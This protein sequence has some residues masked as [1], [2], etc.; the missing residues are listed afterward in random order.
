M[1]KTTFFEYLQNTEDAISSGR[2]HDAMANCQHI[3][4]FFPEALEAQRLL[5][6]VYLAQG[7]LEEAQ[8][9][10]DWILVND[11]ENVVV[12]CD[13]AL[14]SERL[15][16][17]DTALD[18][19][20][21]AYELSRGNSQIRQKFNQLSA[22]VGQQEFMFSRAG[23]ARLYMRGDL[24]TQAEQEW[25]VVLNA[26]PERLD[27]RAGLLETCW[28]EGTYDKVEQLATQILEEIPTC[29][30]ALLLLAHVTST[31]NLERSKELLL[32]AETLDP[33]MVMA[34]ELFSD[35]MVSQPNNPF[36]AMLKK[37]PIVFSNLSDDTQVS[38]NQTAINSM[39]ESN[40]SQRFVETTDQVYHPSN[41]ET[42]SEL[43]TQQ[44]SLIDI[45]PVE[46]ITAFAS[47]KEISN[48]QH[49]D[50]ITT[51]DYINQ[52][53]SD[54][55]TINSSPALEAD[56]DSTILEQQPWFRSEH[57]L[58]TTSEQDTTNEFPS[59]E[60]PAESIHSW[61]AATQEEDFPTPPAWL[62][63]LTKF[64]WQPGDPMLTTS[65]R[66]QGFEESIEHAIPTQSQAES[67]L[68]SPK[69]WQENANALPAAHVAEEPTFFS[70]DENNS[71]M[72]WPEWLKS[73]GA[74]TIEPDLEPAVARVDLEP[75]Q[76]LEF[77]SW[78][79]Q[80]DQT[81]SETEQE[82]MA[83]L[84][85]LD[86]DL[87][88]QGFVP[89][90]PGTL[91]TLAEE[92]SLSSALAEPGNF[93]ADPVRS[94]PPV[95][96]VNPDTFTQPAESTEPASS[97]AILAGIIHPDEPALSWE[98]TLNQGAELSANSATQQTQNESSGILS[99]TP[100]QYPAPLEA[101]SQTFEP[102]EN[103][104]ERVLQETPLIPSYR[105]DAWL[106][107]D[108]ETTMKRP[109]I[110]LPS[111]QKSATQPDTLSM[112]GNARVEDRSRATDINL[113]NKERLL[114]GYQL[115]LAGAYDD[116][117]VEYRIIIRKAPEL[118]SEVI[119]NVRALLKLS[120][121]YSAGFRVLGD[122]Y[123]RQGEYL[124]A[125]EAYNKALTIAKKAKSQNS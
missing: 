3:L 22:K 82:Q 37:E 33:E 52:S 101:E 50:V 118:L 85:H 44:Y 125:M 78:T 114:R 11:P 81:L 104:A 92:P 55:D 38:N 68:A 119:S 8:Q 35:L 88:S 98:S 43:E 5:G 75:E 95:A 48:D 40:G 41:L 76:S 18:C 69:L 10:F 16:D 72:E 80:L 110:R 42:W 116:A 122:A 113:S 39:V 2:I 64:D 108:L 111:M 71:E 15:S 29:L 112:L 14:T 117:M 121:R 106:E 67:E 70:T 63:V 53:E 1:A 13:R 73:L 21:Q 47:W 27:A 105:D 91:A 66:T 54:L 30:K 4:S 24:L 36:F 58:G 99:E 84:E 26:S 115:Q 56:F 120:P 89:L 28:R 34:Q 107:D 17:I 57:L 31:F 7:Q 61:S 51:N 6:E 25:E 46:E 9:T 45:K 86:N 96:Q 60:E 102:I 20:Q 79:E 65:A 93:S 49:S 32:R 97:L 59:S 124:Q 74:E 103:S 87:R 62:D 83:T 94:E 109:A 123:M 77:S 12:Y 100:S 19:Y 90:Q 23:L